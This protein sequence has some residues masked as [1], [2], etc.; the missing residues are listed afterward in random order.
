MT[1]KQ[2]DLAWA[3][4]PKETRYKAKNYYKYAGVDSIEKEVLKD[5]FGHHNLTSDTEPEEMLMIERKKVQGLYA[6]FESRQ[7]EAYPIQDG[8]FWRGSKSGLKYLF[9]DKCLPD[10][11]P[12]EKV[13]EIVDIV[14]DDI[15]NPI[16]MPETMLYPKPSVQVEPKP[17]FHKGQLVICD[18]HIYEVECKTGKHHYALKGACYEAHEDILEPY[19]VPRNLS[20]STSN[21][22]KSKDN[23]L[24]DNMEAKGFGR[25]VN[26]TTKELNLCELLKG[27]EGEK[28]YSLIVGDVTFEGIDSHWEQEAFKPIVCTGGNYNLDGTYTDPSD[29]GVCCLYPSRALYEK[30]PLDPYTAW[31]EWKEARKPK[32]ILQ[33]EIRLISNDGQT[34]ED[35]EI[36]EMDVSGIDLTQAAEAIR[37]TVNNLK[38]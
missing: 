2:Q 16:Q 28:F 27:C 20:Q 19:T 9:G 33:A 13:K 15:K 18:G 11:T 5:L 36:V 25:E 6:A 14:K 17:K 32:Y 30:Y 23:Q 24:K 12:E 26:F 3:C 7:K 38:K 35:S 8:E 31:M 22:D 29:N 21:C 34:I 37:E 10:K 1:R 4:L